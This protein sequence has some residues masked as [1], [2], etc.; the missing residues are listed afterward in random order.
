MMLSACHGQPDRGR[1]DRARKMG[2]TLADRL[3]TTDLAAQRRQLAAA[4]VKYIVLHRPQGELSAGT[5]P[6]DG[7]RIMPGLSSSV[8]DDG[9]LMVLGVY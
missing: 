1:R 7:W 4:H 8:A 3:V 5:R 9:R 2:D 6:M